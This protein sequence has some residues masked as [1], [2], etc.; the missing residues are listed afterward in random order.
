MFISNIKIMLVYN[1]FFINIIL[2]SDIPY[3]FREHRNKHL[4]ILTE[5]SKMLY[6][7]FLI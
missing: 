6:R 4:Q 5:C 2:I 7:G 3:N 1:I